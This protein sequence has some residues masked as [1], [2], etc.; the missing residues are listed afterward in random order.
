MTLRTITTAMTAAILATSL[1]VSPV[2]A[3]PK[4][5]H[6]CRQDIK[7]CVAAVPKNSACTGTGAEK[8]TCRRDH[9]T[10]KTTCKTHSLD[11]CKNDSNP[12]P[13][14]CSPSGAFLDSSVDG[15]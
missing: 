10:V 13:N 9:R 4:C 6:L 8:R 12:D 14:V 15:L 3:K 1:L 11:L 5:R 2:G 7:D